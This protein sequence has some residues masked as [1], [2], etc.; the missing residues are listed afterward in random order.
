[1]NWKK[2]K[3]RAYGTPIRPMLEYGSKVSDPYRLG[4]IK[5]LEMI[6]KKQ[7]AGY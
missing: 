1:M 3:T 5:D 2:V 7:L 4:Q 6:Q